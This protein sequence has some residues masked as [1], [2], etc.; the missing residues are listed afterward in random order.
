[1]ELNIRLSSQKNA[2]KVNHNIALDTVHACTY[3][4]IEHYLNSITSCQ[5]NPLSVNIT[6]CKTTK[7]Y[8]S[9]SDFTIVAAV[10]I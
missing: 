8:F 4:G 1:M 2:L 5:K 9:K 3:L 10:I 6:K 7:R